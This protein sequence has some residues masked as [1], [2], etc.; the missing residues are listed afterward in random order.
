MAAP[1]YFE[2]L[3]KSGTKGFSV[4]RAE[5]LPEQE[6]AVLGKAIAESGLAE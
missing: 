3:K 6:W 1:E 5:Q 2:S 4:H